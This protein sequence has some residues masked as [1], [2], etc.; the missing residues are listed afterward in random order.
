MALF[1]KSFAVLT[2]TIIGAGIFSLPFVAQKSGFFI[3]LA[4]FLLMA[5]A[6]T[7]LLFIYGK[8]CAA[9]EGKHRLPGYVKK[10]LGKRWEKAVFSI[11]TA[12]ITGTIL[13]Y[14]IIGGDFLNAFLSPYIGG[15]PFIYSIIFWALGSLF[16]FCGI[17]SISQTELILFFILLGIIA[18]FLVKS[19]SF[20]DLSYLQ[21]IN[22]KFFIFPYG[23][24][25]FSLWGSAAIPEIKEMFVR[26]KE[27]KPLAKMKKVIVASVVSSVVIYI[28]FTFVVLGVTGPETSEKAVSGLLAKTGMEVIKLGFVFGAISCF[29]SFLIMGLTLKKMLWYDLGFSRNFSWFL[30]CFLPV[31]LFFMGL[32]HFIKVISFTGAIATG[33]EAVVIIL[34]YRSFIKKK[35]SS[36]I[37]PFLYILIVVFG[38]GALLEIFYFLGILT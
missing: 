33:A 20:L 23:A 34:L 3:I 25:L 21:S 29:T 17:K 18:L 15:T 16:I 11:I 10:Y 36:Q 5:A 24:V 32:T 12:G 35:F 28:L 19:V 9:T 4:Y 30:V 8:V 37:H 22:P 31:I 27:E 2:G 13:A 6:S 1:F 14:L 26:A 7:I 38:L